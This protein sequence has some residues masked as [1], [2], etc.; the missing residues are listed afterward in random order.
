MFG[1][2][3]QNLKKYF[4]ANFLDTFANLQETNQD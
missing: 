2:A 3:K 1:S 4:I